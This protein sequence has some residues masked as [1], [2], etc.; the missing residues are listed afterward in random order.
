M[1]EGYLSTLILKILE[2]VCISLDTLGIK[3][4]KFYLRKFNDR[5]F[6]FF[7]VAKYNSKV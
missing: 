5:K 2:I 4:F 6:E 7:Y 3:G 1:F